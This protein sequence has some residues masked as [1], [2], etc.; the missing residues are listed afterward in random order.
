MVYPCKFNGDTVFVLAVVGPNGFPLRVV[1]G[2]LF[3]LRWFAFA[4]FV[5]FHSGF[6]KDRS[7][8]I[9]EVVN[10]LHLLFAWLFF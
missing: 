10:N 9:H 7:D 1:L 4:Y 6:Q 5:N 2:H 3:L 8:I